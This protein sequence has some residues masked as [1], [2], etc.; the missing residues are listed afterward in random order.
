MAKMKSRTI[1]A[2][3]LVAIGGG[4][5]L[6]SLA[7]FI[8]LGRHQA[9]AA[10]KSSSQTASAHPRIR[11]TAPTCEQSKQ[12]EGAT[13][14]LSTDGDRAK[15]SQSCLYAPANEPFT[16]QFTNSVFVVSDKSPVSFVLMISSADDPAILFGENG[17]GWVDSSKV[18]FVSDPVTAPD[19]LALSV[20]ALKPG[21]Y[22]IQTPSGPTEMW[23]TLVVS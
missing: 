3:L 18:I 14:E 13:I 10:G 21:T 20:P 7:P 12:A 2:I 4:V 5:L 15:F 16:I 19:T 8:N 6:I 9:A 17:L 22:N 11:A 1:R 23:A